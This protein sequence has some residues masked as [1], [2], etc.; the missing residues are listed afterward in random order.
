MTLPHY[1]VLTSLSQRGTGFQQKL[2]ICLFTLSYNT[3]QAV[4]ET[5]HQYHSQGTMFKLFQLITFPL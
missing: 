5:L 4:S 1:A 2:Y 3:S